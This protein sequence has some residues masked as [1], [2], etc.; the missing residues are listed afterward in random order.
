MNRSFIK[1]WRTDSFDSRLCIV[2]NNIYLIIVLNTLYMIDFS[3]FGKIYWPSCVT[4]QLF[5]LFPLHFTSDIILLI[6]WNRYVNGEKS[7]ISIFLTSYSIAFPWE[8]SKKNSEQM[9]DIIAGYCILRSCLYFKN[10]C[11]SWRILKCGSIWNNEEVQSTSHNQ[12]KTVFYTR[13]LASIKYNFC[14]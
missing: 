5:W 9:L 10:Y 8:I 7:P 2:I 14:W 1:I 11:Q 12:L 13:L 6:S 4:E 3:I